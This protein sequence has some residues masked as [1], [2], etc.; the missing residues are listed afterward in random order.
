MLLLSTMSYMCMSTL[1]LALYLYTAE[2]YPTR[3][4]A[5]GTSAGTAWL[6]LASIIGPWV[7]GTILA[8]GGLG[9][10]FF[11]FGARGAGGKPRG[12]AVRDRDQGAG[13]GGNFAVKRTGKR[14]LARRTGAASADAA[15]PGAADDA[16]IAADSGADAAGDRRPRR[17]ATATCR[18]TNCSSS[19][20]RA[21]LD[22]ADMDEEQQQGILVA[23]ACPCCGGGAMS[24]SVK[25]RSKP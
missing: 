20:P 6:R 2:L 10:V 23:M 1:S 17:S 8:E 9:D 16:G 3:V 25:L 24:Y 13:A 21:T 19:R 4:R 14:G 11:V 18:F 22:R 5:L 12:G 7:V 15:A